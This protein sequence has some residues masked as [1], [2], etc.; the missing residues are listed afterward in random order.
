M[1][2]IW[3]LS[4][5]VHDKWVQI[6]ASSVFIQLGPVVWRQ[7]SANPGLNFNPGFFFFCSKAFPRIFFSILF[8]ASNCQIVEK[9]KIKL[10]VLFKLSYLNSN[11]AQT[12]G[13]TLLWTTWGPFLERPG[14]LSGPKKKFYNQNLLNSS[15]FPRSQ[16][17]Q[18]CF[19]DW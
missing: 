13:L 1:S 19:A 12:L 18:F 10:N 9:N 14:N 8:R 6:I 17:S 5:T 2:L 7:I 15:T 16:T 3:F 11:F 4:V